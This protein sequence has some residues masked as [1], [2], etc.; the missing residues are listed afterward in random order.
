MVDGV[1]NPSNVRMVAADLTTAGRVRPE[2]VL[3]EPDSQGERVPGRPV[4]GAFSVT[5]RFF[6]NSLSTQVSLRSLALVDRYR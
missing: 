2:P 5:K 1:T 4:H 6:R 3:A